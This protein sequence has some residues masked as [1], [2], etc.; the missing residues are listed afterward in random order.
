V[1]SAMS[2]KGLPLLGGSGRGRRP[3]GVRSWHKRVMTGLEQCLE[4]QNDAAD[5]Q[6]DQ[7]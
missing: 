5:G 4:A 1:R 2:G 7:G 3:L 6:A